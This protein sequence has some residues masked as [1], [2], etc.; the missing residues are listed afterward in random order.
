[1]RLRRPDRQA[2]GATPFDLAGGPDSSAIGVPKALE[3]MEVPLL[4]AT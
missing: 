2:I 4:G 1:M 3:A